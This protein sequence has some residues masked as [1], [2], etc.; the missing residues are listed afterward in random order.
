MYLRDCKV[1]ETDIPINQNVFV[2]FKCLRIFIFFK[3]YTTEDL[4]DI[5]SWQDVITEC[6]SS[7]S[8]MV[9]FIILT[10]CID[11]IFP[12]LAHWCPS[13][14]T[15]Q[16]NWKV[17]HA[18]EDTRYSVPQNRWNSDKHVSSCKTELFA[19]DF[20]ERYCLPLL[21]S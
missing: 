10:Y 7:L 21:V 1:E 2:V 17:Q 18:W 15:L 12:H 16:A 20:P 13:S 19:E 8:F 11:F 14:M 6:F 5:S 3:F 9:V 4:S